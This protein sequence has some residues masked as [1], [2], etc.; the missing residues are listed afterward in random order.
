MPPGNS[1]ETVCLTVAVHVWSPSLG[2]R[3]TVHHQYSD[4]VAFLAVIS[5]SAPEPGTCAP[6]TSTAVV[7]GQGWPHSMSRGKLWGHRVVGEHVCPTRGRLEKG[8]HER[9]PLVISTCQ[10]FV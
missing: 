7:R 10:G 5:G 6:Y 1:L 4:P 9:W 8:L 3:S 2:G